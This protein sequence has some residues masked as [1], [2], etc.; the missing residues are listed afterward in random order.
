MHNDYFLFIQRWYKLRKT[1]QTKG[2]PYLH[3][4]RNK[5]LRI[6]WIQGLADKGFVNQTGEVPEQGAGGIF[7]GKLGKMILGTALLGAAAYGV[8]SYLTKKEEESL[9]ASD[10]ENIEKLEGGAADPDEDEFEEKAETIKQAANRAYTTIQHSSRQA[11]DKVKEA[12]GPRGEE[13]F[14]AVGEAATEVGRTMKDSATK[15]RDILREKEEDMEEIYEK[16]EETA[17]T[18][19]TSGGEAAGENT[20]ENSQTSAPKED[21]EP[22]EAFETKE[23]ASSEENKAPSVERF[24]DEE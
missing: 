19:T 4:C 10:L 23:K 21:P 3:P 24:F 9:D 11:M 8:Y 12:V 1:F 17:K 2:R 7:M 18:A 22:A 16:A 15:I 20:E 14:N 13:V 6:L 5:L